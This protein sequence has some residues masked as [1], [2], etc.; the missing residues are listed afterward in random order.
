MFISLR[1]AYKNRK[2][3]RKCSNSRINQGAFSFFFTASQ[4]RI[5]LILHYVHVL[6]TFLQLGLKMLQLNCIISLLIS[7]IFMTL[8]FLKSLLRFLS[9]FYLKTLNE[10]N[11]F[12]YPQ[13]N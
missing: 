3:R 5:N 9:H 12:F 11:C 13:L 10:T 8:R 6:L 7:E 4:E 2:L 1:L